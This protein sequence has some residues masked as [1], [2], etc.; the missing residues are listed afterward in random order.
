MDL[1][2]LPID[3]LAGFKGTLRGGR[4]GREGKGGEEDTE[5]GRR[6]SGRGGERSWNRVADWLRPALFGRPCLLVAKRQKNGAFYLK[7]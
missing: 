1:I 3:P 6:E 4:G 5:E 7:S 2:A